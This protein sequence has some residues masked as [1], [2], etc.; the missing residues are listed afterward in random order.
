[1]DKYHGTGDIR[2]NGQQN[3]TNKEF[4]R[5]DK[6]IGVCVDSDTGEEAEMSRFSIHYGKKGTHIV[7]AKEKK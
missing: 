3:W 5:A 6:P 4:V 1:M 7:P 2:L